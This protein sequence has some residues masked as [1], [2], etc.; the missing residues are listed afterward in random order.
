MEG[1]RKVTTCRMWENECKNMIEGWRYGSMLERLPSQ[2]EALSS[3]PSAANRKNNLNSRR[4]TPKAIGIFSEGIV[5][6]LL[7]ITE[8]ELSHVLLSCTH[9]GV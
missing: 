3:N 4:K 7:N 2:R 9:S 6:H 8:C 1:E 5:K